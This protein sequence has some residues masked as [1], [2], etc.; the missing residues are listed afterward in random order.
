MRPSGASMAAPAPMCWRSRGAIT[1]ADTHFRKVFDVES[2]RLGN[3]ATNLTL[4]PIAAH[5]ISTAS[6]TNEF[7]ASRSTARR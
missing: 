4:G 6:A 1:L 7:R 3:G 2:L 5:A